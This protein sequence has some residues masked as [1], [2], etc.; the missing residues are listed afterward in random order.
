MVIETGKGN[1]VVESWED[2]WKPRKMAHVPGSQWSESAL[3]KPGPTETSADSTNIPLGRQRS[4][5]DSNTAP[6]YGN[7]KKKEIKV[8]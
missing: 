6:P 1:T 8:L 5:Y 4:N 3:G 7:M 2:Y